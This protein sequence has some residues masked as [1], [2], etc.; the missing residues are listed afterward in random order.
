MNLR[1]N[2]NRKIWRTKLVSRSALFFFLTAIEL[3]A[4]DAKRPLEFEQ[5]TS[6][7]ANAKPGFTFVPKRSDVQFQ[8]QFFGEGYAS[9]G[10]RLIQTKVFNGGEKT[11]SIRLI[12]KGS[13]NRF[14]YLAK[15]CE[16]ST[17]NSVELSPDETA[18]LSLYVSKSKRQ[19][20]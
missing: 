12:G 15:H 16:S 1:I 9:H 19:F 3:T 4:Q 8:I 5:N 14:N 11:F 17:S 6:H 7:L 20:C 13:S 2:T 18:K 10:Y